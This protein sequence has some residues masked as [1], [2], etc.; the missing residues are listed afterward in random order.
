[1]EKII[2][3]IC[4]RALL[5][6]NTNCR[7]VKFR[8]VLSRGGVEDTRIEAKAK[9]TK[10][11]RGQGQRQL[12]RIHTFSRPRTGMLEAEDEEHKCKGS[13]KKNLQK[14][15][16]R[17]SAFFFQAIFK[18]NDVEKN[19]SAIYKILTIQKIV[20]SSSRAEDKT[21]FEDL[22]LRGQGLD[23]RGQGQELQNVSSRP[24]TTSRTPPQVLSCLKNSLQYSFAYFYSISFC[25]QLTYC[26]L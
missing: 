23:L 9:H 8:I 25:S 11:I 2:G 10:K 1:M 12:F 14:L 20:L 3:G 24:K 7:N 13:P 4:L 16:S 15:F 26:W 5:Q 6:K 19:L 21:I 17:F 22:G 18:K